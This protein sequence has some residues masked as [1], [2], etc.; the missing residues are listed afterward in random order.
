[1]IA[2]ICH[3]KDEID[4]LERVL[5]HTVAEGVDQLWVEDHMS[6]DGTWELLQELALE[7]P[8]VL[9]RDETPV[10]YQPEKMTALAQSVYVVGAEWVVPFDADEFF[11]APSG[12]TVAAE[13]ALV[14]GGVQKMYCPAWRYLDFKRRAILPQRAKVVFRAS[15][16]ARLVAGNHDVTLPE[17][18]GPLEPALEV[19]HYQYRSFDQ[20]IRKV[21]GLDAYWPLFAVQ[22]PPPWLNLTDEDLVAEWDALCAVET[23]VIPI[24]LRVPVP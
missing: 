2:G 18:E 14:P 24:P 23:A 15:P 7:L 6:T 11:Y 3:V 10:F 16:E 17:P 5:L 13:L 8:I 1:M 4:I 21:R 20:F 9:L 12:R 19:A 22:G